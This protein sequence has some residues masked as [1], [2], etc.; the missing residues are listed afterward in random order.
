MDIKWK[1]TNAIEKLLTRAEVNKALIRMLPSLPAIEQKLQRESLLKSSLFSA[2]IEGNTLSYSQIESLGSVDPKEQEK[3]EVANILKAITLMR[4]IHNNL[5]IEVLK[6]THS[7]V[8]DGLSSESGKLRA[9]PSAIFNMAGIAVYMTP[10]PKQII[11]LLEDLLQFINQS[12][13]DSAT[14][15][16]G[17]ISHYQFEKIHPFLD[18]NGRVGRLISSLH[19]KKL[20]VTRGAVYT[21]AG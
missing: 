11:P 19:I 8:M 13:E 1:K 7:V 6:K 20:G 21:P 3:K 5:T 4:N 16:N 12:G 14:L 10:P 2:K 18:G 9:E 17:A 15:V